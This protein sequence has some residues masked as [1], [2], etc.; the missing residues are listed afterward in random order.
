MGRQ[1]DLGDNARKEVR[2]VNQADMIF[3]PENMSPRN[4]KL[5]LQGQETQRRWLVGCMGEI[6]DVVRFLLYRHKVREMGMNNGFVMVSWQPA[7]IMPAVQMDMEQ[8]RPK[9]CKENHQA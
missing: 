6:C 9:T 2:R 5:C 4:H 1:H 7:M 8:R 3:D